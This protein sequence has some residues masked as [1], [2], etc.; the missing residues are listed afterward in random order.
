MILSNLNIEIT[1]VWFPDAEA[2][3]MK[4][5]IEIHTL[6]NIPNDDSLTEALEQIFNRERVGFIDWIGNYTR[7]ALHEKNAPYHWKP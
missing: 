4:I 6:G 5:F 7:I 1:E 2:D 3:P